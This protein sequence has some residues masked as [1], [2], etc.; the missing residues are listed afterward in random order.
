MPD[1]LHWFKWR[2]TPPGS[3]LPAAGADFYVGAD[4][5]LIDASR[6][7]MTRWEAIGIGLGRSSP[8]WLIYDGLCRSAIGKNLKSSGRLVPGPDR[9]RLWPDP[10]LL[11]PRRGDAPGRDH[12]HG[13]GAT[14]S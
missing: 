3:R 11:G 10:H 13:D 8:G 4:V 14:S 2:P 6:L 7:A 12:R 9:C 1:E 5:N